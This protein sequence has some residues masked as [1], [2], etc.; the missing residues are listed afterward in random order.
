[1]DTLQ[2]LQD[3]LDAEI[4]MGTADT[5]KKDKE[6]CKQ[7]WKYIPLRG[8]ESTKLVNECT[9]D[10]CLKC[11]LPWWSTTHSMV[12][13]TNYSTTSKRNTNAQLLEFDTSTLVFNIPVHNMKLAFSKAPLHTKASP[14]HLASQTK[15]NT[16]QTTCQQQQCLV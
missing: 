7:S 15:H 4:N 2:D 1:M 3:V 12:T 9:F 11:M 16:H 14:P 13:H 10:W 8:M 6:N 5:S